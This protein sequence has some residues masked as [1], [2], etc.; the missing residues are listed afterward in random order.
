MWELRNSD[1]P[2]ELRWPK[3]NFTPKRCRICGQYFL[4]DDMYYII[5]CN[6]IPEARARNL[7]NEM[8]HTEC[9]QNF[10]NGI[11]SNEVLAEKLKKH[12]RP[13]PAPLSDEQN[14]AVEAFQTAASYYG[15]KKLNVTREKCLKATKYGSTSSVVYNP[16]SGSV[17]YEDRRKDSLFKGMCDRQIAVNV[18]NKMHAILDDGKHD[19]YSVTK[20][21]SQ[22]VEETNKF[23]ER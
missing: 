1:G 10:C 6:A 22:A 11:E 16:Y 17:T 5:V 19:E 21:F 20:V 18:Y 9:W 7:N 13:R 23:F 15:F 14:K 3:A 2:R 8:A 4:A 12:R